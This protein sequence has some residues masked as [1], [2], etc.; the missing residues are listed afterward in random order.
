MA[1]QGHDLAAFSGR[2]I[3]LFCKVVHLRH[4]VG[5]DQKELSD[6]NFLQPDR[7][8]AGSWP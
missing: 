4:F 7:S 5:W 1:N 8:V 2:P 3:H 6:D